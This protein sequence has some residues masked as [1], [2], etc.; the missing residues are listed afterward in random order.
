MAKMTN[1]AARKRLEEAWQKVQ[2]V[3]VAKH[4]VIGKNAPL[5]SGKIGDI[6]LK[7]TRKLK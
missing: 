3:F 4:I 7:W 5:D 2:K 6:L 1:A